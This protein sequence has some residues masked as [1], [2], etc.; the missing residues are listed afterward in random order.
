M[1]IVLH[2]FETESTTRAVEIQVSEDM[3]IEII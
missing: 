2:I 3:F 1:K